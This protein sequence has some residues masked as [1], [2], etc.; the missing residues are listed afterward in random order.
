MGQ[1]KNKQQKYYEDFKPYVE[2]KKMKALWFFEIGCK[3]QI[4][5]IL[6]KTPLVWH[7][8]QHSIFNYNQIF[9]S[10]ACDTQFANQSKRKLKVHNLL[11]TQM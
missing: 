9:K 6:Y 2:K 1:P 10:Y 3:L 7:S 8:N 4:H 5:T 11:K